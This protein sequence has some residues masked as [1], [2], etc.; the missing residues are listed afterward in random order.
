M[1]CLSS[2][3]PGL[4]QITLAQTQS[5]VQSSGMWFFWSN[6]DFLTWKCDPCDKFRSLK[7]QFLMLPVKV[8]NYLGLNS[9]AD[10]SFSRTPIDNQWKAVNVT[11]PSHERTLLAGRFHIILRQSCRACFSVAS[12]IGYCSMLSL[13]VVVVAYDLLLMCF[14]SC[15]CR[16]D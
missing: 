11:H 7:K 1:S 13:S 4:P 12:A 9:V 5:F 14:D 16:L 6:P 8:I 2:H 10:P 15:R 3:S